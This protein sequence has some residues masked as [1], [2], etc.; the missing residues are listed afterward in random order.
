MHTFLQVTAGILLTVVLT[1]ML[2][3]QSKDMATV[4]ML[5]ALCMV[6]VAALSFLQPV[7]DFLDKLQQLGNLDSDVI[8]IVFKTVGVGMIGEIAGTICC[9]SGNSALGKGIQMLTVCVILWLS[10][11][12]MESLID[13]VTDILGD[14]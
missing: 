1:L 13:M 4:L 5:A 7:L 9:D 3:K 8:R 10:M 11:P 6:I 12:L 14:I 2:N